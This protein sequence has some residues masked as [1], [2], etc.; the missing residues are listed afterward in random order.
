MLMPLLVVLASSSSPNH[1]VLKPRPV[2]PSVQ[3]WLSHRK[4][5]RWG[6]RARVYAQTSAD[7]Y[8]LVFHADAA[9]RV[10]VLFPRSPH[11]GQFVQG[12]R[13][14]ERENAGAAVD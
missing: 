4:T 3:I 12:G 10:R 9:G 5:F 11:D 6:V 8:L 13:A 1:A 7:G 14:Y 2:G